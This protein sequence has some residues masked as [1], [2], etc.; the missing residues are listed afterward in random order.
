METLSHGLKKLSAQDFQAALILLPTRRACNALSE[1]FLKDSGSGQAMVL[2]TI[3]QL[4]AVDEDELI[5]SADPDLAQAVLDIPPAISAMRRRLLL[6]QL[7]LSRKDPDVS[8][9]Q[10]FML[11]GDLGQLL[12]QA[13]I[14]NCNFDNLHHLA[15]GD[16]AHHWQTIL[17][18]LSI[19]TQA[20]PDI[21]AEQG[22]IEVVE[23]RKRL[24]D[25]QIRHW[26]NKPP[27]YPVI[28]A[29]S[30]GSHP[31]TALLL[32]AISG[33]PKGAVI[34][35]GLDMYLDHAAWEDVG[36]THPQYVL[37]KLL[38]HL[39]VERDRVSVWTDVPA[40]SL[41]S[42][43][44]TNVMLPPGH[45]ASEPTL[46]EHFLS[47]RPFVG[48]QSLTA[49]HEQDEAQLAAFILR[50]TLE[51]PDKTAALIT[52]DR[53]L[54]T[55]VATLLERWGVV[56]ND[57]AGTPLSQTVLAS[58]VTLLLQ[59]PRADLKPSGFMAF[60]KHPYT[61][62]G[63]EREECLS[64]ARKMEGDFFRKS[65]RG[66]GLHAWRLTLATQEEYA[67]LLQI[68]SDGVAQFIT[69][70]QIRPLKDWLQAHLLLASAWSKTH[71]WQGEEGEALAEYVNDLQVH[72][73][74]YQCTFEDYA[75]LFTQG[76]AQS[77]VRRRYGQHP[78][79]HILGLIEA[80]ML[81]FDHVILAGLNEGTWPQASPVDPWMSPS[82]R[83]AFG[84]PSPDQHM[85]QMAH[86]FVQ[87]AA[88]PEVTLLRSERY[89]V[90]PTNPSRWLLRL[91][92]ILAMLGQSDALVPAQNWYGWLKAIDHVE[93]IE[94][95]APPAVCIA[96]AMMPKRLSATDIEMWVRDPY[97]F[98]A[99]N[100]L[101]LR[102]CGDLDAILSAMDHG[103]ITHKAME[104][105]ARLYPEN[106]PLEAKNEFINQLS[107]GYL[108]H[109]VGA[110]ELSLMRTRLEC[111]AQEVWNFEQERRS[112]S[113]KWFS[114]IRGE[115]EVCVKGYRPILHAK[116]DRIDLLPD[117]TL[118]I[119]D[120]K[121]GQL[122]TKDQVDAALKPQLWVEAIIAMHQGYPDIAS[123]RT[124]QICYV[125]I[126]EGDKLLHSAKPYNLPDDRAV[127]AHHDGLKAFIGSYLGDGAR[128]HSVPR[129]S[130]LKPSMDYARLARV[131]EW[132]KGEI[133]Q[134]DAG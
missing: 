2:P 74:D 84:L 116:A 77:T 51:H 35:P 42:E 58:Y 83:I 132:S 95:C 21:L 126:S 133:E 12:D 15:E 3:R 62:L 8:H 98:Y 4:S 71:L 24:I 131:A 43:F 20:W 115:A 44:L 81:S 120:Y 47:T 87:L 111:L 27:A 64:C 41:R 134:E 67:R 117:H 45:Q 60:L 46:K 9:A 10:A 96:N 37:K 121:T 66:D 82:M 7:I 26:Q 103:N 61:A 79:L 114:E 52:P 32:K 25:L 109:G 49:A 22:V 39:D 89:G 85:G 29:G 97:A 13:L 123:L 90:N 40:S 76:L 122:P 99:K 129:P 100:I 119:T 73:A 102:A 63:M 16:F 92:A 5:L 93:G 70:L 19:I 110:D 72:G 28:A 36:P 48:M 105:L 104:A 86:D 11:A 38:R 14:E 53:S 33:M 108:S 107:Q 59:L 56:V 69:P 65:I 88:H 113:L 130:L 112:H 50:E 80:R 31:S 128:F 78:R 68:V 106:W 30:T 101:K 17:R 94:P 57:S 1:V 54:A 127:M 124:S 34:L 6:T 91:N 55:R 118:R 18:F 75:D 23:R 125:H